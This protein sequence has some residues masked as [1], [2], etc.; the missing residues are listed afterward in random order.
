MNIILIGP[1]GS[2]KSTQAE[3]IR[4][5][6]KLKHI[7]AGELL[8]NSTDPE[9]KEMISKGQLV[10]NEIT[11]KL[12][13]KN[14]NTNNLLDGIPRTQ[15]QA[16]ALDK[17]LFIDAVI[18]LALSEEEAIK[19]LT[20]RKQCKCG[21]IYPA[22]YTSENCECG[23]KLTTR[24]DDTPEISK[25][26]LQTYKTQ[27]QPV[28]DFYKPRN[29]VHKVDASKTIEEIFSEICTIIDKIKNSAQ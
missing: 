29:N 21:K 23:E 18:E 15:T 9:I 6:Y 4:K 25:K 1:Q 17:I 13:Q 28:I 8:R 2:G 24:Q 12:V 22:T 11:M 16:E 20:T 3:L 10:P 26:R 7:Q 14:L 27:T 19:R 5:K